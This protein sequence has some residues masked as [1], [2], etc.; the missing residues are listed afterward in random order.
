MADT[1]VHSDRASSPGAPA[2][3]LPFAERAWVIGAGAALALGVIWLLL[4]PMGVD[5]AAQV[6]HSD[7][8]RTHP[9]IPIDL[10]WFGGTDSLGY[11]F[12]GPPLMAV[13]GVRAC[14]VLATAACAGLLGALMDRCAVP[15]PRLG[16]VAGAVSLAV[17]LY[18]GRI[19]FAVGAALGLATLL[20]ITYRRRPRWVLM[21]LGSLLT[22]AASPLAALFLG[23]AG[24]A[25]LLRRYIREGIV[26]GSTV[27]VT[28]L[29]SLLIGQGGYMPMSGWD[30]VTGV[31]ACGVVAVTTRYDIVRV[32]AL[33]A[34]VGIGLSMLIH[35]E[36]GSNA[37]RL[38]VVFAVP[39]VVAT[40][41]WRTVT[42]APLVALAASMGLP[43]TAS[44]LTAIND[45]TNQASYYTGLLEELEQLPLT[46]RVEV[47]PTLNH[48]ESVYVAEHVPLAR[49]WMT[50]LDAG[51]EAGFFDQRLNADS[52]RRWLSD[53]AVQ[54]IAVPDA[55]VGAPGQQEEALID[56]GL[57][58]LH[59]IWRRSPWTIYAVRNPTSTV[60]GARLVR[61]SPAALVFHVDRPGTVLVR[62]RWSQFLTLTGAAACFEPAAVW[63]SVKVSEP[64]TYEVGSALV[65]DQLHRVCAT[66]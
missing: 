38:P 19:T 54:Y 51:Y 50:Q 52:Y 31:V 39:I 29:G 11:S 2:A 33:I 4:P 48:W 10:R 1:T 55:P 30:V 35:S 32:A 47:P 15:R 20:A 64:G 23:L 17:N 49:G 12:I 28:L 62:I 42:L 7:F 8:A 27:L 58:Y 53:N 21:V 18:V 45:P 9:W 65:P 16:A 14:G 5:L 43:S 56:G 34:A 61:Q 63:T 24:A 36:V 41:R 46:G 25:L 60:E 44:G 26:L 6:A 57:P 22:W 37:V 66:P 59:Q 3:D 40:S 13:I